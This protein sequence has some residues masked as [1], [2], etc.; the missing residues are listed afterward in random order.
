LAVRII[1]PQ[2]RCSACADVTRDKA[3]ILSDRKDIQ[4]DHKDI[5]ADRRDIARDRTDIRA[6]QRDMRTDRQDLRADRGDLR[7]DRG[8]LHSSVQDGR[9]NDVPD[10]RGKRM[11]G[12]KPG[13]SSATLASN[14]AENNKKA[15]AA[16]RLHKAWYHF[17]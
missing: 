3:D 8:N 15:Q 17:W 5:Q 9:R 7:N 4:A 13:I 6:V 12:A 14:T 1:S 2:S 11:D 16:Q 10:Q